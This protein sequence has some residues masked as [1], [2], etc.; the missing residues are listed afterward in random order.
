MHCVYSVARAGFLL[1][2]VRLVGRL[3]KSGSRRLCEPGQGLQKR[4]PQTCACVSL[5]SPPFAWFPME[6]LQKLTGVG[7]LI[8]STMLSPTLPDLETDHVGL[9]VLVWGG[10]HMYCQRPTKPHWLPFPR[11]KQLGPLYPQAT[12]KTMHPYAGPT[13][14][15]QNFLTQIC[16]CPNLAGVS[17]E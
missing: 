2:L 1:G 8:L 3:G 7:A 6:T 12:L 9:A 13:F 5:G 15:N 10:L 16:K 11:P 14:G 17:R 4:C